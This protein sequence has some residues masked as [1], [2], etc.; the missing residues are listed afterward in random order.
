MMTQEEP[1]INPES[2]LGDKKFE[3]VPSLKAPIKS[4]RRPVIKEM[5]RA[6]CTY[7]MEPAGYPYG[8]VI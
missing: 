6:T 5:Q 8:A 3:R 7:S 1:V 2:T 4:V